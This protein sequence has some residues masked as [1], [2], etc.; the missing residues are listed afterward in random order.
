MAAIAVAC[1]F[2]RAVA[3]MKPPKAD[4]E[5]KLRDLCH[6]MRGIVSLRSEAVGGRT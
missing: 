2:D 1:H 4:E 3:Q 6:G 5:M